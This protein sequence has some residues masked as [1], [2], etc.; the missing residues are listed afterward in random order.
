MKFNSVDDETDNYKKD[1]FRIGMLTLISY[2]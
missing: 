2:F 1:I